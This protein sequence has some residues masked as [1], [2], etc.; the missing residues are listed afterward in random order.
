MCDNRRTYAAAPRP[1]K[2]SRDDEMRERSIGSHIVCVTIARGVTLWWSLTHNGRVRNSNQYNDRTH[3][4]SSNVRLFCLHSLPHAAQIIRTSAK[5][6]AEKAGAAQ[7]AVHIEE[8]LTSVEIGNERK[9]R[10]SYDSDDNDSDY[11][12]YQG[13]VGRPGI[14]FPIQASISQTTFNCAKFGNGYFADLETKCQVHTIGF[15]NA[16]MRIVE[17]ERPIVEHQISFFHHHPFRSSTFARAA[18]KSRSSVRTER[19]SSRRI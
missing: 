7:Y 18:K 11:E 12:I 3:C 2:R 4:S 15:E 8:E 5:S 16:H 9:Q 13:V 17:C 14:D 10:A 19:F 6:L 1:H